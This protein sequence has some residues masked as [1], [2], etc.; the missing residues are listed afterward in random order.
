MRLFFL[1]T[2][3]L[4][5]TGLYG[6]ASIQSSEEELR[7]LLDSLRSAKSDSEKNMRVAAFQEKLEPLL[8]NEEAFSYPFPA[9]RTIGKIN[10]SDGVVRIITWNVEQ[11]DFSQKYYGYI[12]KRDD[13]RKLIK[14]IPLVDK[15][16]MLSPK[17]E[18]VLTAD[19]WYGA[20]YYQIV[21]FQKGSKMYYAL[22]GWDGNLQS[23]NTKLIDV[24]SFSG[25]GAKLGYAVFKDGETVRK[26]VFMEHSEKT[27]MSLRYD[28]SEKRII[29]DHLS[30]ES[31]GMEGFYE[32]YVPDMTYDA[33]VFDG[34]KWILKEDVIG[35]NKE[36][37]TVKMVHIDS[38]SGDVVE[39]D[40]KE[41]KW[42]DPTSAGAPGS[43]EVH[44][45]VLHEEDPKEAGTKSTTSSKTALD[46][47][48][49]RKHHKR[50]KNPSDI[51]KPS[52][53]KRR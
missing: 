2:A 27:V 19:N 3:L 48:N 21:P 40:E 47:Y 26:R 6:Q 50:E 17:P 41:A 16:F 20:L 51:L 28:E 23:S 12:L 49:S 31:P 35:R 8:H 22:L 33:F 38:K 24:L 9:L 7:I 30:P 53:K 4:S 37:V 43:S 29:F 32:Y 45:A 11:D 5:C 15:S 10:S 36:D 46:E 34:N 39:E 52:E 1:F 44:I 42:V 14:V 18:D 25:T 13:R